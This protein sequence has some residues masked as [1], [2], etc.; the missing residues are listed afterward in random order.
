MQ[1][2]TKKNFFHPESSV[3]I[4]LLYPA[5]FRDSS[6]RER[7]NTTWRKNMV[8]NEY[9]IP[10]GFP[11]W[12][13]VRVYGYFHGA[14]MEK[15]LPADFD[16]SVPLEPRSTY[17]TMEKCA[18]NLQ[19]WL[20]LNVNK[21]NENQR[22]FIIGQILLGLIHLEKYEFAHLNLKLENIYAVPCRGG[23]DQIQWVIGDFGA[24][25]KFNDPLFFPENSPSKNHPS[26]ETFSK[27]DI[28]NLGQIMFEI[29]EG[30]EFQ[31]QKNK[32]FEPPS[33]STKWSPLSRK[34]CSSLLNS[35]IRK[36]ATPKLAF[37][38]LGIALFVP[39]TNFN[40]FQGF[41]KWVIEKEGNLVLKFI[42]SWKP[43]IAIEE[44]TELFF[45]SEFSASEIF[46]VVEK[47]QN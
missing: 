33:L 31:G 25:Q 3:A 1:K 10:L 5:S 23:T 37:L 19:R 7:S 35:D 27:N 42:S 26:K 13:I 21:L 34:I 18:T 8:D 6:S 17:F 32:P 9:L 20:P 22:L 46:D 44:I 39:Y 45:F 12:S 38:Y 11:H 30:K 36:R 2:I 40:S 28:F 43:K 15:L 14:V 16:K 24:S 29:F 47:I 4:K 41:Q